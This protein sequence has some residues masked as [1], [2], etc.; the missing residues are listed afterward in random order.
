MSA[1]SAIRLFQAGLA[2]ACLQSTA[3]LFATLIVYVATRQGL[4]GPL[5]SQ[6]RSDAGSLLTSVLPLLKW[7]YILT[8]VGVALTDDRFVPRTA[9]QIC[10]ASGHMNPARPDLAAKFLMVQLCLSAIGFVMVAFRQPP[11]LLIETCRYV[12]CSWAAS[13]LWPGMMSI[14]VAS[15]GANARAARNALLHDR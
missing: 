3:V 9:A 2:A 6:A 4:I 12:G 7:V 13:I 1:L 10:Q 14:G 8:A 5:S 15:F 11:G